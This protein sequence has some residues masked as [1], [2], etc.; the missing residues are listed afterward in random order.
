MFNKKKESSNGSK[1]SSNNKSDQYYNKGVSSLD[2]LERRKNASKWTA[3]FGKSVAHSAKDAVIGLNPVIKDLVDSNSSEV[4]DYLTKYK[5]MNTA[6]DTD[7]SI[8]KLNS[9]AMGS[10]KDLQQQLKTGKFHSKLSGS[11]SSSNKNKEVLKS[12]EDDLDKT[13]DYRNF[14]ID[15]DEDVFV[16]DESNEVHSQNITIKNGESSASSVSSAIVT[17]AQTLVDITSTGFQ[18]V[19]SGLQSLG[20]TQGSYY[21][22]SLDLLS[23]M[24]ETTEK[25]NK[26]SSVSSL[27]ELNN[28]NSLE[29]LIN[30]NFTISNFTAFMSDSM[31]NMQ[32]AGSSKKDKKKG[33]DLSGLLSNPIQALTMMGTSKLIG[34]FDKKNIVG[35][36]NDKFSNVGLNAYEYIDNGRLKNSKAASMAKGIGSKLSNSERFK[37][38]KLAKA[39]SESSVDKTS[40]SIGDRLKE[41]LFSGGLKSDI[42]VSNSVSKS[43]AV[44]FDAETHN[45]ITTVIPGYLA[46]ILSAV[47]G[48]EEIVNEYESGKWIT[49]SKAKDSYEEKAIKKVS[50]NSKV[51]EFSGKAFKDSDIQS[52][53]I[54]KT[55]YDLAKKDPKSTK[56]IQATKNDS[57]S[58]VI[59]TLMSYLGEDEEKLKEFRRSILSSQVDLSKFNK[60]GFATGT[61]SNAFNDDLEKLSGV[62]VQYNNSQSSV[63]TG[64]NN[65]LLDIKALLIKDDTQ[66]NSVQEPIVQQRSS[67]VGSSVSDKITE[68]KD[69]GKEA[70]INT[71]KDTVVNKTPISSSLIKN[72]DDSGVMEKA[73]SSLSAMANI[74][75]GLKK[76]N[77]ASSVMGP[78]AKATKTTGMFGGSLAA[79]GGSLGTMSVVKDKLLDGILNSKNKRTLSKSTPKPKAIPKVSKTDKVIDAFKTPKKDNPVASKVSI[80]PKKSSTKSNKTLAEIAQDRSSKVEKLSDKVD[81][82]IS[83]LMGKNKE[84]IEATDDKTDSKIKQSESTIMDKVKALLPSALGTMGGAGK[85]ATAGTKTM[86][87]GAKLGLAGGLL[88]GAPLLMG[89]GGMASQ[90]GGLSSSIGNAPNS[91]SGSMTNSIVTNSP[92]GMMINLAKTMT[93]GL[94]NNPM[95]NEYSKSPK[96]FAEKLFNMS[97]VG[98]LMNMDKNGMNPDEPSNSVMGT[99]SKWFSGITDSIKNI[100]I[101]GGSNGSSSDSASGGSGGS[102]AVSAD[103]LTGEPQKK[104]WDYFTKAGYSEAATAGMMGNIQH[105]ND[106]KW[107][108]DVEELSGGGGYGLIQWTG[109]RRT[110]LESYAKSKGKSAGDFNMQLEYLNYE[111]SSTGN[112][113]TKNPSGMGSFSYSEFKTSTDPEWSAEAFCWSY[114]RPAPNTANISGRKKYAREFFNKYAG[115]KSESTAKASTSSREAGKISDGNLGTVASGGSSV[116]GTSSTAGGTSGTTGS[117]STSGGTSSTA[118]SSAAN[119]SYTVLSEEDKQAIYDR[120]L[121]KYTKS[122]GKFDSNKG[123][124]GKSKGSTGSASKPSGSSSSTGNNG[125]GSNSGSNGSSGSGSNGSNNTNNSSNNSS[126]T[127]NNKNNLNTTNN[128]T[129]KSTSNVTNQSSKTTVNNV[130]NNASYT[131]NNTYGVK[132]KVVTENKL[133]Y[134]NKSLEQLQGI[135]KSATDISKYTKKSLAKL[136]EILEEVKRNSEHIEGYN[137]LSAKTNE[138]LANIKFQIFNNITNPGGGGSN[139]GNTGSNPDG[140]LNSPFEFSLD[141]SLLDPILK[142][143]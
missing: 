109:L 42:D 22:D 139:G 87:K 51:Q 78:M 54:N 5:N 57:N 10:I 39:F 102:S 53:D 49:K 8:S 143:G 136:V 1:A 26:L 94:S 127:V 75:D 3:N 118:S 16:T 11:S 122:F 41:S 33:L 108:G 120:S 96:S 115:K 20:E 82:S 19:L 4:K 23:K 134:N 38:G 68:I 103:G 24:A 9:N 73:K 43:S 18:S 69:S 50:F 85:V 56:D 58:K 126:S 137:E 13:V 72:I 112:W 117:G 25:L 92:M 97:P 100:S 21:G 133:K 140:M 34:K 27:T 17:S 37:D 138:M 91:V 65:T 29:E 52:K 28:T 95:M 46:K 59:D 129:T 62:T 123:K 116:G 142:G 74:T 105:E 113:M 98:S 32:T 15:M 81:S 106:G 2:K 45:S 104:F 61:V 83:G 88:A 60:E 70:I 84:M 31:K 107:K 90:L 77:I 14:K 40:E 36:L 63:F 89:A 80:D 71:V 99:I 6:R 110:A 93:G 124:D 128:S 44:S 55:L 7:Q 79:V 131:T 125:S 35:G 64:I 67:T 30:G 119:P 141:A 86:G 48:N 132:S 130:Y 12:V 101:G 66:T 135:L 111:M 76:P 114:E 121:A 47:G